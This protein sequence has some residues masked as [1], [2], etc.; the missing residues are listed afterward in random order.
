MDNQ[1]IYL[2]S[3]SLAAQ[4]W[5]SI[6]H[7]TWSTPAHQLHQLANFNAWKPGYYIRFKTDDDRLEFILT[8]G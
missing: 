5:S 7:D 2:E 8:Y 1:F 6:Y 4:N 3:D